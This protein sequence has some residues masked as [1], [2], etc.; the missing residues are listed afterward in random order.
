M[1]KTLQAITQIKDGTMTVIA[2]DESIDRAGDSLKIK[3][4]NL[5]NFKKNPVLQAGHDYRPQFTIGIAKNIRVEGTKLLFEPKFHTITDLAKEIKAMYEEGV[6]KAWSVGFIPGYEKDQKNE[7]LEVSAV[8]VPAN[9]N[10]L[11]MAKGMNQEQEGEIKEKLDEFISEESK[12]TPG[13]INDDN[14]S[15]E[16]KITQEEI[17]N[18]KEEPV[19]EKPVEE[20]V[21]ETPT[22]EEVPVEKTPV[23]EKPAEEAPVETPVVETPVEEKPQEEIKPEESKVEEKTIELEKKEGRTISTKNKKLVGNAI[24]SLKETI[25][26]LEKLLEMSEVEKPKK[27]VEQ[28]LQKAEGIDIKS[29]RTGKVQK[30]LSIDELTVRTLKEISKKTS[31]ALNKLNRK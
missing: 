6:L 21:E 1:K 13:E 14:I 19:E 22:E 29:R 9:A 7:L 24:I 3:D 11:V 25:D 20:P 27:S 2:S 23:E 5:K 26:A 18:A 17:D 4:W 15:D 28:N 8:A 16:N 12:E 31:F 10:A 30:E